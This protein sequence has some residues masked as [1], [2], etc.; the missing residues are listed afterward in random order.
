M[1]WAIRRVIGNLLDLPVDQRDEGTA[2]TTIMGYLGGARIFRVHNVRINRRCLDTV[3]HMEAM[4]H[5]QN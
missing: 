3:A 1:P 5:G 2:A 4:K